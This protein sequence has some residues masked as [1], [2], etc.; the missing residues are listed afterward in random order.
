MRLLFQIAMLSI[1]TSAL[2]LVVSRALTLDRESSTA[3]VPLD[4]PKSTSSV[5]GFFSFSAPF[6]LFPPN[7]A[8]SLFED[9]LT[10]FPARPAAF[11]PSLPSDG[12]S[13]Q[14]WAGSS[15]SD[16]HF[17]EGEGEGE[18]G[19]SDIPGWEDGRRKT[20]G[21]GPAAGKS[22]SKSGSRNTKRHSMG[23]GPG[24]DQVP[25]SR[26]EPQSNHNPGD[27]GT[28]DY[29]HEDFQETRG[30]YREGSATSGSNHADIQSIQET[31]E[32][33]G[34]IALLSRGGCGF[35]EKVKWAQRRGA[36]ALIVGDNLKG[37]PLIQM[38]ARGNV[39]N[40]T[41]PSV[42]TSRMTAVLLSSLMQPRKN[43]V[44]WSGNPIKKT[45]TKS[46]GSPAPR[47]PKS[48]PQ[49][50]SWLSNLFSWGARDNAASDRSRPPS[51]GRLDWV[52]VDD[53]SD[54]KD[55][56]IKS[57]LDK[58]SS[59]KGAETRASSD[60]DKP[61]EDGFQIGVHDW[62]DPDLVDSSP[63]SS[64]TYRNTPAVSEDEGP[65]ER[66][67]LWITITPTGNV[68]PLFDTLMVLVVSPLITL[69]VVYALLMVR[70]KIRRR[71]WRAPKSVV[72]QLPVR[73]YQPY[74]SARRPSARQPARVPAPSSASP[75]TPL[76]QA[77]AQSDASRD[78]DV[79]HAPRSPSP[80]GNGS[81]TSSEGKYFPSRQ[82]D[83]VICLEE[84]VE[85]VSQVMQLPCGHE[86]HK[87]CM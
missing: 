45:K 34:K 65:D 42:F 74:Q 48:H 41:I 79:A 26:R 55:K 16:D 14:V 12:L 32:I 51:S 67:G 70:A 10:F 3:E 80:D 53:W 81:A 6:S 47:K 24:V 83:C 11:G 31:A 62:R 85:G 75:L 61:S 78:E 44:D 56:L 57:G 50:R 1:S 18:L 25:R 86:F 7:A 76:L 33:T 37:G 8:I 87:E 60:S 29:L 46:S 52:L 28:D 54:E 15:F 66:E 36:V 63:S 49:R 58:A 9:N 64:D 19:C 73:T 72:A 35:L 20:T 27:D 21:K 23:G 77:P 2:I 5:G 82:V 68:S 59:K 71:R 13:G 4:K 39:D 22:A 69:T 38:F 84:Y 30:S 40:V 43:M 17:Q